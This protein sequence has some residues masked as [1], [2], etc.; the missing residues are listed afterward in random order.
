MR[1]AQTESSKRRSRENPRARLDMKGAG[2]GDGGGGNK[3]NTKGRRKA[4]PELEAALERWEPVIG[5]EI[6]AQLS[7]STKARKKEFPY[8]TRHCSSF[9]THVSPASIGVSADWFGW[10]LSD[11]KSF[12]RWGWSESQPRE[13]C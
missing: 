12:G 1:E 9:R 8:S 5:I 7:S 13:R 3:G 11:S 2:G 10:F 6:H 4:N